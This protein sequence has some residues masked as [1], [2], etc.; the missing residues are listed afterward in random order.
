MSKT[1]R[2][3]SNAGSSP[4]ELETYDSEGE[5]R[6]IVLVHGWP[7]N[8]HAW[9]PQKSVLEDAGYR[10]VAF[11]RRGFGE[12]TKPEAGYDYDT[13]AADVRAIVEHLGLKKPVLAGFSMGGGEVARYVGRFGTDNLG[14][15]VFISSIAPYLL[16]TKDNPDGGLQD[17][18]IEG[19]KQGL[20]DDRD[21]FFA[22]FAKNFYTARGEVRVGDD[23]LSTWR[24]LAAPCSTQAALACIDAFSRTDLRPDLAKIDVP[25]LVVHGDADAIVPFEVSGKRTAA[26]VDGAKLVVLQGGPHGVLDS[27]TKQVNDALL[28]F[29]GEL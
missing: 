9:R 15:V 26:T 11:D 29:L 8:G 7:L 16:K 18:D 14:A 5:G 27:H 4:V 10:V 19:M 22:E 6:P 23:V 28:D 25:C 17:E 20:R 24:E 21:G 12:S 3:H 1:L 2:I 13:M